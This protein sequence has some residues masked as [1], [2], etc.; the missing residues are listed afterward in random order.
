MAVSYAFCYFDTIGKRLIVEEFGKLTL[1]WDVI[2]VFLLV[3]FLDSTNYTFGLKRLTYPFYY[4]L[5]LKPIL[6][7]L[8]NQIILC[9]R[10]LP[11]KFSIE[12]EANSIY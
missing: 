10:P 9:E 6:D 1:Y 11:H 3:S 7:D 8:L 2:P 4:L 5:L 12:I